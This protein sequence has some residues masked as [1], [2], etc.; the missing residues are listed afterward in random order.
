MNRSIDNGAAAT[1]LRTDDRFRGS[2]APVSLGETR[3]RSKRAA[4]S[5]KNVAKATIKVEAINEFGHRFAM[6]SHPAFPP[7]EVR[8]TPA[9]LR[10]AGNEF[11]P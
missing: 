3:G 5:A 1:I 2:L 10:P 8:M 6:S 9:W 11:G 7:W 4:R